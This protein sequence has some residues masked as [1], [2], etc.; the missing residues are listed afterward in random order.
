MVDEFLMGQSDG[1]GL[2]TDIHPKPRMESLASSPVIG[3]GWMDPLSYGESSILMGHESMEVCLF[4]LLCSRQVEGPAPSL[5]SAT[6][7]ALAGPQV[8]RNMTKKSI[9]FLFQSFIPDLPSLPT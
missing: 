7:L 2:G 4:S 3:E 6:L 1:A 8:L 9:R 5:H